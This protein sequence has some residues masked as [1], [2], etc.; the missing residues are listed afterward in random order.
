MPNFKDLAYGGKYVKLQQ[1]GDF[2]D[3]KV[4]VDPFTIEP[5]PG[6][7]KTDAGEMKYVMNYVFEYPETGNEK[8]WTNGSNIVASQM[9]KVKVGDLVRI[10]RLEKAGKASYAV[11]ILKKVD[12]S[13][14]ENQLKL[15][16]D[17]PVEEKVD[18]SEIPF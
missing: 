18:S 14:N 13:E 9:A 16:P 5:V 10:I 15:F 8:I 2:I 12:G 3:L 17:A 6:K 7:F 11:R 1:T 4:K